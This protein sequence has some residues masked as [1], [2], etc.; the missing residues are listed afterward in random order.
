MKLI[1]VVPQPVEKV[2]E[3]ETNKTVICSSLMGAQGPFTKSRRGLVG[4]L[5]RQYLRS[6]NGAARRWPSR[7]LWLRSG[8]LTS[9]T[10]TGEETIAGVR[11]ISI[12]SSHRPVAPEFG[13]Y[14]ASYQQI[15]LLDRGM[16]QLQSWSSTEQT[17]AAAGFGLM[18]TFSLQSH[19]ELRPQT[20]C[21]AD[22]TI[23]SVSNFE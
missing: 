6:E 19:H 16:E 13:S 18:N 8:H 7:C 20:F 21:R 9:S 15:K 5:L 1:Q 3:S 14:L 22:L 4:T 10:F 2:K 11:L 23:R 17:V 12:L